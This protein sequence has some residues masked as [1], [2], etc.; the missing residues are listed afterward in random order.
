MI[1]I[2]HILKI[3]QCNCY[4]QRLHRSSPTYSLPL[5]SFGFSDQLQTLFTH[6]IPLQFQSPQQYLQ[7]ADLQTTYC[8][9]LS[10]LLLFPRDHTDVIDTPSY[11]SA[12]PTG[13]SWK[14]SCHAGQGIRWAI[15]P[16]HLLCQFQS[17]SLNPILV[18]DYLFLI[19]LCPI[20][21]C[22]HR[23]QC[24]TQL[25]SLYS[26]TPSL[27][28]VIPISQCQLPISRKTLRPLMA[29]PS[30]ITEAK[31]SH[32]TLRTREGNRN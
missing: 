29:T 6:H 20:P 32:H 5:P 26:S 12:T 13:T 10:S 27:I 3:K 28:Q 24:H 19:P 31:R 7:L 14:H 1:L 9:L 8:G 21:R 22:L 23:S 16:L 30:R 18:A 17:W 2:L 15:L 11:I 25:S 4:S